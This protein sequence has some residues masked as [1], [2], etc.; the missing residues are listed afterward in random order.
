M[1]LNNFTARKAVLII[2][3]KRIL[4]TF[5]IFFQSFPTV[6]SLKTV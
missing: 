6:Q 1:Y 4:M 2:R 3:N 5:E